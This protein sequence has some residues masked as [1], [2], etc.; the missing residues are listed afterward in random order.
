MNS[1]P[2]S[3]EVLHGE[4]KIHTK[5]CSENIKGRGHFGDYRQ[6]T[7]ILKWIVGK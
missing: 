5:F 1:L 6:R 7:V 2:N 3:A 4:M